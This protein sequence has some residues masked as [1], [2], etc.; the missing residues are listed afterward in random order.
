VSPADTAEFFDCA[1][2]AIN[3]AEQ[4]RQWQVRDNLL[5][6]VRIWMAAEIDAKRLA[7]IVDECAN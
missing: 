4:A 7:G 1:R 2:Y 5:E 3:L 6:M